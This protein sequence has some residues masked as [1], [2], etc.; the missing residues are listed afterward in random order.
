MA[1][2]RYYLTSVAMEEDGCITYEFIR[3][4]MADS[5]ESAISCFCLLDFSFMSHHQ[6]LIEGSEEMIVVHNFGKY[7]KDEHHNWALEGF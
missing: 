2:S 6:I 4:I 5:I 3:S 7:I 1:F